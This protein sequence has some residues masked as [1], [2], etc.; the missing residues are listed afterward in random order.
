MGDKKSKEQQTRVDVNMKCEAGRKERGE[1]SVLCSPHL[2]ASARVSA[3]F[4][5]LNHTV[6]LFHS[7]C[8]GWV[9]G[10]SRIPQMDLSATSYGWC[11]SH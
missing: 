1:A 2:I 9:M 8:C 4:D 11:G 7:Q 10:P 5:E 3:P 6:Q